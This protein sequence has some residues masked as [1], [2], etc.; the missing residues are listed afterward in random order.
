MFLQGYC[1]VLFDCKIG[2]LGLGYLV[3]VA[4]I[5][6]WPAQ[7]CRYEELDENG[8]AKVWQESCMPQLLQNHKIN[9]SETLS[10]HFQKTL[11]QTLH[12]QSLDP[13]LLGF[14]VQNYHEDHVLQQ[15]VSH[16]FLSWSE[17]SKSKLH[18]DVFL[19][20]RYNNLK[21]DLNVLNSN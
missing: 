16:P 21:K 5:L 11:L 13:R 4:C 18:C 2:L 8:K 12:L 9:L 3:I 17:F 7:K 20:R 15:T 6:I 14:W 19:S 10:T 1:L